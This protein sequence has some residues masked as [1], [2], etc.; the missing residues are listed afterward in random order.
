MTNSEPIAGEN[1]AGR[2]PRFN[3][4]M[5]A[6]MALLSAVIAHGT[7]LSGRS[8]TGVSMPLV[9]PSALIGL[10]LVLAVLLVFQTRTGRIP[11]IEVEPIELRGHLKA[12]LLLSIAIAY[13]LLMQVVGFPLST[14]LALTAFSL[15]L[16][17]RRYWLIGLYAIGFSAALYA[18][19]MMALRVPLPLGFFG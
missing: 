13:P 4:V 7:F 6:V 5:A 12:A 15:A 11:R 1:S 19:F 17:E 9:F 18:I 16:G 8:Q 3:Y 2:S 14:T 10:L